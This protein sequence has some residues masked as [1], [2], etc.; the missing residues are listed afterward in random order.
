MKEIFETDIDTKLSILD[1][2]MTEISEQGKFYKT[3]MEDKH[4]KDWQRV[5]GR[6]RGY[7]IGRR[8]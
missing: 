7:G 5:Y 6:Y 8:L 2:N 3:L 1:K 4:Y